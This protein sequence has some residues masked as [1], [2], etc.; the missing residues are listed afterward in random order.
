MSLEMP[1]FLNFLKHLIVFLSCK[2]L[3]VAF[4][5]SGKG[6]YFECFVGQFSGFLFFVFYD[7]K[8]GSLIDFD[9]GGVG[10]IGD[11]LCGLGLI[12]DHFFDVDA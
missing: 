9:D 5:L 10:D 12:S 1:Q 11:V 4:Q 7:F 2:L 8:Y 3:T 6:A